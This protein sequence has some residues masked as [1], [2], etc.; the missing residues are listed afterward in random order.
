[1]DLQVDEYWLGDVQA[2]RMLQIDIAGFS[3]DFFVGE[4]QW[5]KC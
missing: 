2:Y 5:Q 1:M 4:D 3:L